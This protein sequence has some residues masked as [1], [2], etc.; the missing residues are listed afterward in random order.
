MAATVLRQQ[1]FDTVAYFN[2]MDILYQNIYSDA[3]YPDWIEF[4][5]AKYVSQ[6]DPLYVQTQMALGLTSA[7]MRFL[8]DLALT[9]SVLPSQI[10]R[11]RKG[12]P[13][14]DR[15]GEQIESRQVPA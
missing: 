2:G 8:F 14:L 9:G 5:S 3:N 6:G 12:S 15:S 10:V 7:E 4:Y 13:V 1:F 11:N